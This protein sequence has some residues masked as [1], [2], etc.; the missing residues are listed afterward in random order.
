MSISMSTA[1]NAIRQAHELLNQLPC[2]C[3]WDQIAY[4]MEV[5]AGIDRGMADIKANRVHSTE[6]VMRYLGIEEG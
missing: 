2:E 5:R 6:E 3:D 1:E 4:H